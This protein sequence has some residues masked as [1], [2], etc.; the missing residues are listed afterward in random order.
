MV[1]SSTIIIIIAL[2]LGLFNPLTRPSE[3]T[4][5]DINLNNL[6]ILAASA[7]ESTYGCIYCSS[8]QGMC[9]TCDGFW[10]NFYNDGPF[11]QC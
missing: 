4:T 3:H 1:N 10:Y 2:G 8:G 5:M 9:T 7:S 6:R 11:V